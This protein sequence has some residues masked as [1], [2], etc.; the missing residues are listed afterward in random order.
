MSTPPVAGVRSG[1]TNSLTDVIG[2]RVG[3]AQRMGE[4]WLSGTTVVLAPEG[5]AV[6]GVDVRGGGPGTRETDLLDPRNM[7]EAVHAVVLSGGSAFGLAAADGVM[8]RLYDAGVG[9]P[10][11]GPGE[12]VP[13]V[14]AAVIFDLGR[15]GD[16]AAR[17]GAEL[18][19]AAYDAALADG[20]GPVAAGGVGAGTGARAGGLKGGVGSA[21]AVLPD[22]TTIAALVVANPLGSCVDPQTGELYAAR[23]GLGAEFSALRAPDEAELLEALRRAETRTAASGQPS[24]LA[25]TIGVVATD[26]TL[27]KAQC[28]KVSGVAHDGMARA[29]RPVHTMFDGDTVFTLAAG[30]RPAPDPAAFH[31]L[32]E[33]AGDCFT[34]AV[35]H[36][37]LAAESVE[38]RDGRCR[39]YRDAFST[40]FPPPERGHERS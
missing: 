5:G 32:L 14:P 7:V 6:G 28:A 27:T 9:L 34:R 13:I 37:V 22:G 2:F 15:G 17:P 19:A 21:S 4:G 10:I 18:G 35:G 25:T 36:A 23:F 30:G 24:T 40:A 29:I 8:Q 11:G 39:S 26:A 1:A 3:H 38:M 16:F 31:A 33:A 20:A 12:V